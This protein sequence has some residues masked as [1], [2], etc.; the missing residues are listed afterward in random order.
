MFLVL[1]GGRF[2]NGVISKFIYLLF[3]SANRFTKKSIIQ[4]IAFRTSAIIA[5]PK[6]IPIKYPVVKAGSTF[7]ENCTAALKAKGRKIITVVRM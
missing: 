2:R 3:L 4:T 6:N 7:D 5:E 1:W